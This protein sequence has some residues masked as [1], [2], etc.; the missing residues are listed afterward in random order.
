MSNKNASLIGSSGKSTKLSKL[1]TS[2][3]DGL[4]SSGLIGQLCWC[5]VP[6]FEEDG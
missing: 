1:W 5:E 6:D 3:Q 2:R 4:G